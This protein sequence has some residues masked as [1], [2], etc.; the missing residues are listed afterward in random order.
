MAKIARDTS[1]EESRKLAAWGS[2]TEW[3]V[4]LML[5]YLHI[6]NFK[7]WEDMDS[8]RRALA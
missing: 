8:I 6:K 3:R 2:M 7:T 5:T 4:A 1:A